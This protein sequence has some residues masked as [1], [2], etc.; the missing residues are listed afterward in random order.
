MAVV[1]HQQEG[2]QQRRLDAQQLAAV[3]ATTVLTTFSV[4]GIPGGSILMMVPVMLAAGVPVVSTPFGARGMDA[5]AGVHYVAADMNSFILELA[6]F[7]TNPA[8]YKEMTVEARKL[9]ES[10]YSWGIIAES[11]YERIRSVLPAS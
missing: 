2:T 5:K 1:V 6:I 4:P 10:T 3:A 8:K 11:F 9:A 7:L